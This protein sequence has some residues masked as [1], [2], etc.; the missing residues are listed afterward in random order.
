M[1]IGTQVEKGDV[2]GAV[3][4]EP[5]RT[6]IDGLLRGLIH[7]GVEVT[8]GLKLG[9]VYD[10]LKSSGGYPLVRILGQDI[11]DEFPQPLP[12][13][14]PRLVFGIHL[15]CASHVG[16]VLPHFPKYCAH[17]GT[18]AWVIRSVFLPMAGPSI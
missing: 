14:L 12:S 7:H 4:G 5:V 18:L 17:T 2:V 3:A 15:Y 10:L 16:H 9:D 1:E 11:M 13:I 8:Q 6:K